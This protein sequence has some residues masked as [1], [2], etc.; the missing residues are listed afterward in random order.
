MLGECVV[1]FKDKEIKMI[2]YDLLKENYL[3]S[4]LQVQFIIIILLFSE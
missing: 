4:K 2:S 3:K 1:S